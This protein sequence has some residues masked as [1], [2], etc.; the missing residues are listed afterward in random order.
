MELLLLLEAL[1]VKKQSTPPT[2][3]PAASWARFTSSSVLVYLILLLAFEVCSP[4]GYAQSGA[5]SIEGT[6]RDSSGAV[7]PGASIH[8]VNR[9][10]SVATEATSN[11]VGF[12]QVPALFAARYEVTISAQGMGAFKSGIELLVDQHAVINASLTAG[13][14]QI[15]ID[16]T[17]DT[18]QLVTTDNG[19]LAYD[20]D[21]KRIDQL[22]QNGRLLLNETVVTTPGLEGKGT[23]GLMVNG[24]EGE[25][26]EFVSDGVPLGDRQFGGQNSSQAQLP[27]PDAV[28]EVRIETTNVGA[29]YATPGVSIITTKSGTNTFHGSFF[30][31]IRNNAVGIAKNRNNLA[32]FAAPHLVRNEFGASGGGPVVIP[33]VYDGRNKTFWF[34]AY[35]RFSLAQSAIQPAYVETAAWRTG[36]FSSLLTTS[37]I[38]LYDPATTRNDPNCNGSGQANPYCRTPFT[39]NQIPLSRQAPTSKIINDITPLP[40]TPCEPSSSSCAGNLQATNPT[41]QVIPNYSARLDH[42]FSQS[43]R[44]F[45]RFTGIQETSSSLRN[46]PNSPVTLAADGLPAAASGLATFPTATYAG[47]LGY[48]HIFS[49][50]FFSET[51]VSHQW[52]AQHNLAGGFPNT[53]FEQQLGLP[54]N[55]GNVGFPRIGQGNLAAGKGGFPGTQ[56]I[57][58]VSQRIMTVDE[59]LTKT[60]G[61]HQLQF[62]GRYRLERF[63]DLI[64]QSADQ[65]NFNGQGT[66][67]L[68]SATAPPVVTA[69]KATYTSTPNTGSADADFF[70]GN[71]YQYISVQLPNHFQAHDMEVDAYFQDTFRVTPK[72]TLNLGVR[73][74]DHPSP[75]VDNGLFNTFD[76]KN[77]AF[78]LGAPLATLVASGRL[79]QA[80]VTA[81]QSIGVKYETAQDAGLPS[82]L[83]RNYPWNFLPRFGFA[84][85]P[86]GDNKTVFRGGFGRY[87]FPTPTRSFL[88]IPIR[89]N[90]FLS[91]YS[92]DYTNSA[93]TVDGLPNEQLRYPQ[94][95]GPWTQSSTYLPILGV[96]SANVINSNALTGVLPGTALQTISPNFSPMYSTE[97]NLTM[98]QSFR[99]NQAIRMSWVY[100][101][102]T[103]FDHGY[104]YNNA[105][106]AFAYEL[107]TG[108]APN[109]ANGSIATRPYDNKTYG[110]SVEIQKNGWS[111]YNAFQASYEKRA[112]HGMAFQVFYAWAKAFRVGD[113]STRDSVT[114]PYA[115]YAVTAASGVTFNQTGTTNFLYGGQLQT[116]SLPP[117]PPSGTAAWQDYHDLIRFQ[118]YLIDTNVPEHH[119][120]FNAVIDLP[121]GHNKRFL[122]KINRFGDE[123][124]G[125]WQIA[126]IGQVVSQ[127]FYVSSSNWGSTNPIQ[128]YAGHGI[129]IADCQS[130]TCQSGK[131]W[132][133]GF[134]TPTAAVVGKINGLPNGYAVNSPVS[135]AYSSPLNFATDGKTAGVIASTNNNVNVVTPTGTIANV[136]YNPGVATNPFARTALRGP[137]N[138]NADISLYKV[139]PIKEGVFIRV[140]FDAFNAF[141][142]QGTNNPNTT[143]GEIITAGNGAS[144]SYWTPRQVQLTARL[145]F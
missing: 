25:S 1:K 55:F 27:D 92:R 124:V 24:L 90:P 40:N 29:Q 65:V 70:L 106:S 131:L 14:V 50:S 56:F 115:N 110:D 3:R 136:G 123:L 118:N 130:G 145:T 75:L 31:T 58:G 94:G 89:N 62:G 6:V 144:T 109:T 42:Y 102:G 122:S 142:I 108:S 43:N 59:N 84:Y 60:A 20:L 30:E 48:N 83:L 121:F 41:Y 87:I 134:I 68:N 61:H 135:P 127:S 111:N 128:V 64:D 35:E 49:P 76:F 79:N 47:A 72:L 129:P 74:E 11:N 46:N 2:A 67:L 4:I 33:H 13:A 132:F 133:N 73:W 119:V 51:I 99:G 63:S 81:Q 125:G 107:A 7:I 32:S 116:P 45:V 85:Q 112:Y 137:Y 114:Y 93:Q 91:S 34:A 101:H 28:Q 78:V 82:S 54:N 26:M 140:N 97:A 71:A 21:N 38:Q 138:Y 39:N 9:S 52:F 44:A 120:R 88:Q 103:N 16:V 12:Y 141:N 139:F 95:S 126:T 100:T 86:R 98:E 80:A 104:H 66:A 18:A 17:A 105:P 19:T 37:N 22:P 5:G 8:V 36:D 77:D 57:Y 117:P 15:Q 69:A 113:N 53:N 143:T 10:T 23:G 96:N